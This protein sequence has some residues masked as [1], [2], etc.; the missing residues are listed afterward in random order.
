MMCKYFLSLIFPLY[1]IYVIC[2]MYQ[3]L[4]VQYHGILF[5][6]KFETSMQ[7]CPQYC[8]TMKLLFNSTLS[9]ILKLYELKTCSLKVQLAM[10]GC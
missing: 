9:L 3:V 10:L 2:N 5:H 6:T 7:F 4:L 1:G 8:N